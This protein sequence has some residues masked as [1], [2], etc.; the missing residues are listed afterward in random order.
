[1]QNLDRKWP[2]FV[3]CIRFTNMQLATTAYR[4]ST[5]LQQRTRQSL[6]VSQSCCQL[7]VSPN[8]PRQANSWSCCH[9]TDE[10][11]SAQKALSFS[12]SPC[13]P[14]HTTHTL[15]RTDCR[16]V[17]P[18]VCNR[19]AI[20]TPTRPHLMKNGGSAHSESNSR[21]IRLCSGEERRRKTQRHLF[22]SPTSWIYTLEF[23]I[24]TASPV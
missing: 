20:I 14:R 21:M 10:A 4:A 17:H 6:S 7:V 23:E 24:N 3:W 19:R 18:P 13:P 5:P 1:M 8:Y 16:I 12:L 15:L 2:P 22:S 11:D 9:G